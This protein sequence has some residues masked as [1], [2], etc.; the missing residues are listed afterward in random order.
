MD[1][2]MDPIIAGIPLEKK[3]K[4]RVCEKR[5]VRFEN[6]NDLMVTKTIISRTYWR[7]WT[8]H[9]SCKPI[10]FSNISCRRE[11]PNVEQAA[12]NKKNKI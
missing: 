8:P 2:T 3:K 11:N 10:F 4:K 6:R 1:T 5:I 9:E 12:V 7:L